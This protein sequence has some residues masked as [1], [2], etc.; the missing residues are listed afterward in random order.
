MHDA[1]HLAADRGP[2]DTRTHCSSGTH[3]DNGNVSPESPKT[4]W[5]E[6][7]VPD[8]LVPNRT[9]L[10]GGPRQALTDRLQGMGIRRPDLRL[11]GR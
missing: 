1:A 11:W 4:A 7:D 3:Y 8:D 10:C 9:D 6:E 5:E 2:A